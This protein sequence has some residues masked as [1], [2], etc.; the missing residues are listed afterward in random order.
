MVCEKRAVL[1]FCQHEWAL[2]VLS[3]T[4]DDL[5]ERPYLV[6]KWVLK[7]ILSN[8]L[9]LSIRNLMY[10]ID[11][12]TRPREKQSQCSTFAHHMTFKIGSI[13]Y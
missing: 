13:Q 3:G 8:N 7:E 11:T 12:Q 9:R 1:A 5:L 6:V 10:C 2:T 4:S